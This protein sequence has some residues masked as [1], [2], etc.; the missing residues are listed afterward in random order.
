MKKIP[1]YNEIFLNFKG[2]NYSKVVEKLAS[3]NRYKNNR[4]YINKSLFIEGVEKEVWEYKIGSYQVIDKW[5][6][7]RISKELS[8][9]ELEHL[10][11]MVKIIK[12]TIEI[13]NN[14]KK[15]NLNRL[16]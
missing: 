5:L 11:K 6:K 8:V 4:L 10:E 16:F 1:S 3:K 13:Q 14:L 12:R 9:E 15:I 7:Y 2:E